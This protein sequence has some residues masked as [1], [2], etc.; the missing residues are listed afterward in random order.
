[1][2]RVLLSHSG[3]PHNLPRYAVTDKT[4]SLAR[5]DALGVEP[6]VSKQ[7]QNM[8]R[9]V[10]TVVPCGAAP[11]PE[12]WHRKPYWRGQ[13]LK[14]PLVF[15]ERQSKHDLFENLT[16]ANSHPTLLI[17]SYYSYRHLILDQSFVKNFLHPITPRPSSSAK[18]LSALTPPDGFFKSSVLVHTWDVCG[19]IGIFFAKRFNGSE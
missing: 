5:L 6:H 8:H 14:K 1:M 4:H 19:S 3:G 16:H 7:H 10:P 2:K 12:L 15:S 18:I 9:G 17:T 13:W 11:P